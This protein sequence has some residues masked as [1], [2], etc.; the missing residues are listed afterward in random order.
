MKRLSLSNA[1]KSVRSWFVE[2]TKSLGCKIKIDAMGNIFAIRRGLRDGPPTYAGSHLDTQPA[3][4]RYDGILG[5][6]AGVEALRTMNELNIETEFP[7]GVVNWTNEEGARFPISMVSSGVWAG[8]ISLESAHNLQE[9]GGGSATMLSELH[10]IG[11]YGPVEAS[12]KANPIG[13][14]FEIHIEQVW[15]SPL[16]TM[17]F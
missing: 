1:D 4:G 13:A 7:T 6:L 2:T 15:F 3:G 16:Y 8:E 10:R 9:V 12:Y 14:H 17:E 11:Y 5:V